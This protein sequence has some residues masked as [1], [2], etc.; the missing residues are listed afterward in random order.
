MPLLLKGSAVAPGR[1]SRPVRLIDL[2][3]TIVELAGLEPDPSWQGEAFFAR[4]GE[5]LPSRPA[6]LEKLH[7]TKQLGALV[8][9]VDGEH[10]LIA[11][12]WRPYLFGTDPARYGDALTKL[13]FYFVDGRPRVCGLSLGCREHPAEETE[14]LRERLESELRR[15]YT[16][17]RT[18]PSGAP[19]ELDDETLERLRA[20]GYLND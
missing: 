8:A 7:I 11:P 6:L 18:R 4:N 1:V 5:A 3:P 13:V 12:S 17:R 10:K 9:L 14:E 16:A 2:A 20:L 19:E 15:L